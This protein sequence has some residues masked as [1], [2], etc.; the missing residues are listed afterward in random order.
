M[1][2]TPAD[3]TEK[4][5]FKVFDFKASGVALGMYN[6]DEVND[7][8]LLRHSHF[9]VYQG[10]CSLMLSIRTGQEMASLLEH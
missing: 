1:V 9:I 6:T 8:F 3:G 4:K 2:F 5:V 7:S 10:L